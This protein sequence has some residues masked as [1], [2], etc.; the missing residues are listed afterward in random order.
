MRRCWS[1]TK[2]ER[3][4]F[5]QLKVDLKHIASSKIEI[6]TEEDAYY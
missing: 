4:T 1:A 6:S 2:E 3:S 5:T